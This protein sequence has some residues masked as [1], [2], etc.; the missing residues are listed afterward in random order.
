ML[1]DYCRRLGVGVTATELRDLAA[2]LKALPP[3]HPLAPLL[4]NSLE[5]GWPVS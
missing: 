3:D 4:R 5:T 1:Q 2:S